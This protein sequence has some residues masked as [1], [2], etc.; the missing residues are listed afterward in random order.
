LK[1]ERNGKRKR[2]D[3][4]EAQRTRRLAESLMGWIENREAGRKVGKGEG[5]ERLVEERPFPYY[6]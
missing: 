3:N 1:V 4:A 6:G 5:K 2:R